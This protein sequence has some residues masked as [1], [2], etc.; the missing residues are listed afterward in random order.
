MILVKLSS[1]SIAEY[2]INVNISYRIPSLIVITAVFV[3][4]VL[5]GNTCFCHFCSHH[6]SVVLLDLI[7]CCLDTVF[8]IQV[9]FY[10]AV[11]K[12][13]SLYSGPRIFLSVDQ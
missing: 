4:I 6:L 11:T 7:S 9:Y 1:F 8:S 12:A 3:F 10:L 13:S 2:L 5:K